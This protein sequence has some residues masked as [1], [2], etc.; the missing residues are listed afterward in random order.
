MDPI[1][2]CESCDEQA[3]GYKAHI[4]YCPRFYCDKHGNTVLGEFLKPALVFRES[5]RGM[6]R[7][8]ALRRIYKL[9]Q[10]AQNKWQ[11]SGKR[12]M[13]KLRAKMKRNL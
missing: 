8:L 1:I 9:A 11:V 12:P 7:L 10:Q 2:K 13:R 3:S 4:N 6:C 5:H